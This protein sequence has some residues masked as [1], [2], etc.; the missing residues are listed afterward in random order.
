MSHFSFRFARNVWLTHHARAALEKRGLD[1]AMVLQLIETGAILEKEDGH[2]WIHQSLPGRRD[3]RICAAVAISQ[4][5]VVKTV[6]V[7]W[8]LK[9]DAP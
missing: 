4:S 7:N 6:M 9:E 5:V 2:C 8:Q 1:E 3:N